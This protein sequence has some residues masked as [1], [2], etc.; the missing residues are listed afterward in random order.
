M[1]S[2]GNV[3]LAFSVNKQGR[4]EVA[5]IKEVWPPTLKRQTGDLRKAYDA[6]LHA[7][8]R[9]LPSARFSPA[10]IGGCVVNQMVEQ[11]FEFSFRDS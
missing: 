11:T 3:R 8:I 1:G 2:V 6:F 5:T 7:V 10:V 4:V 9:D